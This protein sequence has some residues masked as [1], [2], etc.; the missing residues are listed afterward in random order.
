MR[1][2]LLI[3]ACLAALSCVW[4]IAAH[5]APRE[6]PVRLVDVVKVDGVIDRPVADYLIGALHDAE[7]TGSTVVIQLTT[8]GSI[9]I[10]PVALAERMFDATVPVVVWVGPAPAHAM[11]GGLLLVDASALAVV[12][13]GAGTGPLEPLDLGHR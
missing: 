8:P 9:D 4:P 10:D 7:Q 5:A 13:P 12:A 1:R 6:G 3:A 2:P 11:G